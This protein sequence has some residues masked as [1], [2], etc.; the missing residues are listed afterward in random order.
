MEEKRGACW[1]LSWEGA[2][3]TESGLLEFRSLLVNEF[4]SVGVYMLGHYSPGTG[5][6]LA[7]FAG[8]QWCHAR[9]MMGISPGSKVPGRGAGAIRETPLLFPVPGS[10]G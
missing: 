3:G 1:L 10:E 4:G 9:K 2:K 8:H 5:C 6:R 7:A